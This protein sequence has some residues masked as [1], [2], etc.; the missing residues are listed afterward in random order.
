MHAPL[1]RDEVRA[2]AGPVDDI[3]IA[4]IVGTGATREE[5]IEAL[6]WVENDEAMLDEGRHLASGGRIGRLVEI[7]APPED[8]PTMDEPSSPAR[9]G[10]VPPEV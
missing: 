9:G 4:E 2:V 6:A 5:L 3:T 8:D 10:A 1:T 7:L